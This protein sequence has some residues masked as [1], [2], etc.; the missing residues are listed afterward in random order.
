MAAPPTTARLTPTGYKTP[1]GYKSTIALT[2]YPGLDFWEMDPKPPDMDGGEPIDTSTQHNERY[3]TFAS[4]TL[5]RV[6]IAASKCAFDPDIM[7]TIPVIINDRSGA[8]TIRF[9]TNATWAHWGFVRRFN[10][11]PLKEGEFPQA[12]ME[13]CSTCWDPVNRVEAGPSFSAAAGT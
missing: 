6:G 2:G 11:N 7:G 8:F 13:L 1:E 4:R 5:I 9:P 10:I 3:H 12:D